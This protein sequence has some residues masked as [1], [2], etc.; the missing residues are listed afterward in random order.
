M[1]IIMRWVGKYPRNS[2]IKY[3]RFIPGKNLIYLPQNFTINFL[4][5]ISSSSFTEELLCILHRP[6][7]RAWG[8]YL[9]RINS[10]NN[11]INIPSRVES[12]GAPGRNNLIE[13]PYRN[14]VL[15]LQLYIHQ[16]QQP[17]IGGMK[18]SKEKIGT[19]SEN[20]KK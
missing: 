20:K 14:I 4:P 3:P 17:E 12:G 19:K 2:S 10:C 7:E 9:N 11:I 8:T 6:L 18:K 13:R 15:N 5:T 16:Q 1:D